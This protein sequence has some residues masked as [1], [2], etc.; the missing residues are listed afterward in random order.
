MT[1]FPLTVR[2]ALRTASYTINCYHGNKHGEE[3]FTRAFA[4]SCNSAFASI[5]LG[6]DTEFLPADVQGS[7]V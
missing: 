4:K 6:L 5:G 7:A 3:D 1:A 2:A